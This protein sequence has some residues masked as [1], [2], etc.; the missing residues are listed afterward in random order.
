MVYIFTTALQRCV[1][2]TSLAV[3][4]GHVFVCFINEISQIKY[5]LL[6]KQRNIH[7]DKYT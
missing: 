7:F 1:S 6:F 2:G 5:L 3:S 4:T